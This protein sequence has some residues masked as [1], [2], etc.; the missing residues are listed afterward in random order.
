MSQLAPKPPR[1]GP[2]RGPEGEL[3]KALQD[4]VEGTLARVKDSVE[5]KLLRQE[6]QVGKFETDV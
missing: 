5:G 1:L 4:K 6:L 3:S 2:G